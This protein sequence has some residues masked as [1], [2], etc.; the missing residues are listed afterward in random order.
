MKTYLVGGAVRDHLLNIP[1]YDR[2]W[3]VVGATPEEMNKAGFRS[4]GKDF[5]VF[6]H[7][8]THEEHALARKEKKEGRGYHGFIC[9]FS[10]DVTLEEDLLR[11]DLTINAMAQDTSG[12]IIDPYHGQKDLENKLLRHVSE[13]FS[14]DPLRVLR[15]ARFA[16]RFH[17][18]GFSVAEETIDLM[19]EI[20]ASGELDYLTAERVWK[21]TERAL[22]EQSPWVFFNVLREC[23]ALAIIFPE[24]DQLFGVPQRKEFHPEIDTGLHSMMVLEQAS[25]LSKEITVRFAALTHDLGKGITPAEMLP[26]HIGHEFKGLTL[27]DELC[28]RLKVPNKLKELALLVCEFHTQC[29]TAFQLKPSTVLKLL[30]KVDAWR[31]PERFEEFLLACEADARGRTGYEDSDYPQA[32]YLRTAHQVCLSI[33]PGELAKAGFKGA[34]IREEL[35][36]QRIE[37]LAKHKAL[38]VNQN[39]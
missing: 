22:S 8:D 37:L 25:L 21:E 20:S 36:K 19:R 31:K 39:G 28:Q 27:V 18:L 23:D 6:L 24:L 16:A 4:V 29:H 26:R 2:D 34:A 17:H 33:Q 7:P 10:S 1:V 13:A 35:N 38:T 3:V 9:D 12:E 14:E 32:D 30:D 15:V 5:P 11:R